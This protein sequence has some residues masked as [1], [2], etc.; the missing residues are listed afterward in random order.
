MRDW[1]TI[2]VTQTMGEFVDA[3][4]K[5]SENSKF[6]DYVIGLILY[7]GIIYNG[8]ETVGRQPIA[9]LTNVDLT[10]ISPFN[11][12]IDN[13]TFYF[14]ETNMI[15]DVNMLTVNLHD[16]QDG[17]LHFLFFKSD[18]SYRIGDGMFGDADE[19]L[20]GRF[21]IGT[22]GTFNQFYLMAQR[23]GTGSYESA[24]EF[25]SYD[26][27]L[28]VK[29]I[30]GTLNL[31][32]TEGQ[33]KRSGIEFNDKV[34]PDV[35]D[36][37]YLATDA[38]PIRYIQSDNTINYLL[39]TQQSVVTNKYLNYETSTLGDVPAGKYTIQRILFDIYQ[40]TLIIQYGDTVYDDFNTCIQNSGWVK[41][42]APYDKKIF[43]PLAILCIKS[44]TT[45]LTSSDNIIITRKGTNVDSP[46]DALEDIVARNK[47]E[48]ALKQIQ[49]TNQNLTKEIQNRINGDTNLQSSINS[50]SSKLNT[51]ITNRANADTNLQN[52]INTNKTNISNTLSSLNSHIA[53]KSYSNRPHGL[54]SMAW[55]NTGSY[56][57]KTQCD[58]RYLQDGDQ[59]VELNFD[60][61]TIGNERLI[62]GYWGKTAPSPRNKC[63]LLD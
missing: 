19:L 59:D 63:S 44:G 41:Y 20:F 30:T 56:Y 49:I 28:F 2:E 60:N 15:V 42:P 32:L 11:L 35:I 48:E 1:R 33:V 13:F 21:V 52:Q 57:T 8:D 54:G 34:S 5:N 37:E 39:S 24:E 36:L 9:P 43:L 7:N 51:E 46:Y 22:D 10:G 50:L 58:S 14:K 45:D 27:G 25:Y 29:G 17:K 4:N 18:L 16:Y 26:D 23:C 40:Q 3:F 12:L 31:G 47:A 38:K 61:L 53:Q 62:L 6:L 55:Q